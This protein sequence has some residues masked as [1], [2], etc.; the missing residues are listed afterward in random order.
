V[1]SQILAVINDLIDP[2]TVGA[3]AITVT[4]QGG[5]ASLER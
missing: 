1:N 3:S 4:P 5:S 2:R